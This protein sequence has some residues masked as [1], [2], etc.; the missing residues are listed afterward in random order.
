MLMYRQT[1]EHCRSARCG[2]KLHLSN[3]V[4]RSQ[5]AP[6]PIAIDHQACL[7]TIV[8]ASIGPREFS[9]LGRSQS[10]PNRPDPYKR[11]EGWTEESL[12]SLT[13]STLLSVLLPLFALQRQRSLESVSRHSSQLQPSASPDPQS[14]SSLPLRPYRIRWTLHALLL[15]CLAGAGEHLSRKTGHFACWERLGATRNNPCTSCLIITPFWSSVVE[16][17]RYKES[18][19]PK[20]TDDYGFY[21]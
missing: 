9:V 19:R 6:Y 1:T 7:H 8:R 14:S 11:V 12:G 18:E 5:L 17:P 16:Y 3:R 13:R 2:D 20:T 10:S 15:R 21:R 4:T